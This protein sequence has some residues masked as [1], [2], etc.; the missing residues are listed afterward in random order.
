MKKETTTIIEM[1]ELKEIKNN[2]IFFLENTSDFVYF[3]DKDHRFKY[4]SNAFANLS[5]HDS[6]KDIIG[7]NDF[8]IFPKEQAE[9]YFAEEEKLLKHA[10]E[11]IDIEEQYY[12]NEGNLCWLSSSKKVIYDDNK[13]I[14][15]LFGLS[16]DITEKKKF[17]NN[18]YEKANF[19][20]LTGIS[21]RA[22]FMEQSSKF[23]NLAKR[24]NQKVA[25]FSLDL[26]SFKEINDTYGHESGDIILKRIA[27]RLM[28]K[29]RDSDVIGRLGGDKFVILTFID[30]IKSSVNIISDELKSTINR[31][32]IFNNNIFKVECSVGISL[33]PT[34]AD[35]IDELLSK[36]NNAM[37]KAKSTGK[38]RTVI[39]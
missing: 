1:N 23:I 17:E 8:D 36:A 33:F 21:N 15:G 27:N 34:N 10:E 4:A 11:I 29:F 13:N 26:D 9:M 6:W 19:D 31:D 16:K 37:R 2:F 32:I 28:R 20:N 25:L 24:T 7:K 22:F 12:D 14:I 39:Y 38:N 30:E 35:G 3:K 18:L 5:N